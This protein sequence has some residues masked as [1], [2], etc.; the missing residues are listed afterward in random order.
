MQHIVALC[1]GVGGAKLAEGLQQVLAPGELSVIVN[2]GDD[3]EHRG[4]PICPDLDTVLY[5]LAGVANPDQGWGRAEE[6]W[7]VQAEW[8]ELG[9]DTW[10]Q[11]GDRDIALHLYRSELS[12]RGMTLTQITRALA[13]R[14][15]IASELLP[16]CD[17]PAPTT[18]ST[19]LGDL[20]FQ[21]YFV[22]HRCVPAV[23]GF[24]YGA[25]AS[26]SMPGEVRAAL[27]RPD[28]EGIILCPSNPYLSVAPILAVP[29][30]RE[31]LVRAEIPVI[32]VSPLIGGSAVKGP[33][34]KIMN[35][36]DLPVSPL[37]I[38]R[39]YRDF[40]DVMVIDERDG[41]LIAEREAGD[42]HIETAEILM[43]SP[44]DRRR[45]AEACLAVLRRRR[46]GLGRSVE[47][48]R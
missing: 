20:P 22:K 27:E 1:G 24:R 39:Q 44:A 23:R 13:Q 10:F 4:L 48:S 8:R 12:S 43:K 14:F 16:M 30:I 31:S 35:E 19:E 42:P 34:A 29:G 47:G 40:L 45:L 36:L 9:V 38:A 21:E 28:L 32:A 5:T 46:S 17:Q 2:T 41:A 25:A 11:L 6:T 18:V 15:R 3:F 33:A 26:G 37:E 7:R